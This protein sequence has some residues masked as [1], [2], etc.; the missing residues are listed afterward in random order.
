MGSIILSVLVGLV[1]VP[2]AAG[3]IVVAL[4]CIPPRPPTGPRHPDQF[5]DGIE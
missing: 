5:D 3:V 1:A 4:A 2:V